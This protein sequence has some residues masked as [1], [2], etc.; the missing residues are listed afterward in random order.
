MC[1][2][3]SY[4]W[5][6]PCSLLNEKT[7]FH[8]K[9]LHCSTISGTSSLSIPL[10]LCFKPLLSLKTR[11][12]PRK[13]DLGEKICES[14]PPPPHFSSNSAISCPFYRTYSLNTNPLRLSSLFFLQRIY[15]LQIEKEESMR[16]VGDTERRGERETYGGQ[17]GAS[18]CALPLIQIFAGA[19][20]CFLSLSL[21]PSLSV[22]DMNKC[23]VWYIYIHMHKIKASFLWLTFSVVLSCLG[24]DSNKVCCL[25]MHIMLLRFKK[26]SLSCSVNKILHAL[27]NTK[28][29]DLLKTLLSVL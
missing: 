7:T 22:L 21:S 3:T 1:S 2:N 28:S 27:Q 6:L 15:L 5:A 8:K 4:V 29:A 19:K 17:K 12:N 13:D 20:T 26:T 16:R 11:S 9:N 18:P 24:E 23:V 10:F 25:A 14:N